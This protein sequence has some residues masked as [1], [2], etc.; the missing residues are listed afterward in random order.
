MGSWLSRPVGLA[1]EPQEVSNGA[2]AHRLQG[3]CHSNCL[4]RFPLRRVDWFADFDGL[5][6]TA[7]RHVETGQVWTWGDGTS[8]QLGNLMR[9]HN[10]LSTPHLVEALVKDKAQVTYI[11]CGQYHTAAVT[12]ES[13]ST[14]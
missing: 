2:C 7:G 5:A 1:G 11:S 13:W 6:F 14:S 8:G 10:M 12:S 3:A 9:K 4:W